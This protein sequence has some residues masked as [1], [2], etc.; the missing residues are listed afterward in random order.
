MTE[1][2][3]GAVEASGGCF[4]A[5]ED[6]DPKP[7]PGMTNNEQVRKKGKTTIRFMLV[8]LPQKSG[9]NELRTS[10]WIVQLP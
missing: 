1:V 7:Q 6:R 5:G 9:K 4:A 2:T 10:Y 3:I 8:V